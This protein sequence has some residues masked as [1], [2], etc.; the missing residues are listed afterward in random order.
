MSS[1]IPGRPTRLA[2][3]MVERWRSV[4]SSDA[5]IHDRRS[6]I[7]WRLREEVVASLD[8]QAQQAF[9]AKLKNNEL[10][11]DL[12]AGR[13]NFRMKESYEIDIRRLDAPLT[14]YG[15][16]LQLSLFEPVFD[17]EFDS[18]LERNFAL[19]LDEQKALQWWHRVAVRQRGDYYLRG[20]RQDRIWP[21]FVAMAGRNGAQPHVLVIETKGEHLKGSPDT[22]YK[23]KVLE[24]LQSA[25]NAGS[26]T[27]KDGP[28]KGTFRLVFN[29][30]EFPET[31]A[32]LEGVYS[33]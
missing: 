28:A 29:E 10:S 23:Q 19:Y 26:M 21:D 1:Q 13:P 18:D 9:Q 7:A 3:E 5:D 30:N 33:A 32:G 22:D 6:Y 25:F 11:F 27:I 31:T 2:Q 17:R 14:K 8:L 20:W 15:Q 12:Q 24:T 4:G 16:Q